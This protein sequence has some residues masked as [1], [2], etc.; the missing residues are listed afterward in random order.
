M[1]LLSLGSANFK[2]EPKEKI[3]KGFYVLTFSFILSF[4]LIIAAIINETGR[5]KKIVKNSNM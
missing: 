4:E 5:K 1:K 3:I 2:K